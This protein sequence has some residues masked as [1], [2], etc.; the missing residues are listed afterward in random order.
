M[1]GKCQT[2]GWYWFIKEYENLSGVRSCKGC[3][4]TIM[5][6]FGSEGYIKALNEAVEDY[7][8]KYKKEVD[9]G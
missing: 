6:F 2:C 8:G 9:E 1:F 3:Y 7:L 4:R 5:D